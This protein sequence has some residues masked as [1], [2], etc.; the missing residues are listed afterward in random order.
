MFSKNEFPQP[1]QML[2]AMIGPN[3]NILWTGKPN[4]KCFILEAIFNPFLPFAAVWALF[5]C[6]FIGMLLS[7][8]NSP[9][10]SALGALPFIAFFALH[11]MPVWIY[12]G[13][14]LFSYKRYKHTEFVITDKGLYFS[15]GSF[16]QTVEHIS[17]AQISSLSIKRGMFDQLLGVGDVVVQTPESN[18]PIPT[19]RNPFMTT[20]LVICDIPDF[21]H[22]YQTIHELRNAK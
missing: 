13:G 2:Y 15:K 10:S 3:E 1:N 11:L 14:V 9:A 21:Q 6:F 5:D 4:L 8:K 17:F 7:S 12:L 19:K 20:G 18:V 22:V 16:T